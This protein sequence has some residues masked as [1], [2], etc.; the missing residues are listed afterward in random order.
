MGRG[1]GLAGPAGEIASSDVAVPDAVRFP[2]FSPDTRMGAW[3]TVD[4]PSRTVP[5][6]QTRVVPSAEIEEAGV[7]SAVLHTAGTLVKTP[8]PAVRVARTFVTGS[9]SWGGPAS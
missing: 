4:V 7:T 6:L 3:I 9:L 1:S 5:R 8:F 2:P